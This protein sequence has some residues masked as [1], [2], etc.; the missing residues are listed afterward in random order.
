MNQ[1]TNVKERPILFSGPMV[2]AILEGRKTQT[3]R[4]VKCRDPRWEVSDEGDGTGKLW[5]YWPCYVTGEPEC[6]PVA[7]PFGQ[8]GERLWVR[9]TWTY[10]DECEHFNH[11]HNG[12]LIYQAANKTCCPRK[13]RPSIHMPRKACRLLLEVAD[14]CVERLQ[15]ITE[16]D[17]AAEGFKAVEPLPWWQGYREREGVG[18]MHQQWHGLK[19]PDWM[20]EPKL[21]GGDDPVATT[22]RHEFSILWNALNGRRGY[23]WESNP[24]VWRIAFS[25]VGATP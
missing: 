20:I 18:L 5:P 2:R 14:V 6:I 23:S 22:A 12:P 1:A 16:E 11:L 4:V 7:C 19:P 3:R 25:V 8:P 21:M 10:S 15:E 17:A 9:E 13:W 24:W